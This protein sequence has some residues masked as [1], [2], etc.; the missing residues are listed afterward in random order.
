MSEKA[1]RFLIALSRD[2]AGMD[3]FAKDPDLVL[4]GADLTDE[5]R[6][7]VRSGDVKRIHG[8]FERQLGRSIPNPTCN[9]QGPGTD[10][11]PPPDTKPKP[12][13]KP[14]KPPKSGEAPHGIAA[15]S[16]AA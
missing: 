9:T 15:R 4:A 14:P 10:P 13:P 6:E 8:Y 7:V 12:R 2:P 11:P 3:A 16:R 5:D 1:A